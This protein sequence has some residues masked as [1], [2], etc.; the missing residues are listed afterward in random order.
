MSQWPLDPSPLSRPNPNRTPLEPT[1]PTGME[2]DEVL[3]PRTSR[4]HRA[5]QVGSVLAVLIVVVWAL[6][7]GVAPSLPGS[8]SRAP[9]VTSFSPTVAIT[10]NIS[11]WVATVTVNGRKLTGSLPLLTINVFHE[12]ANVVTLSA[13]PFHLH[14]CSVDLSS[15]GQTSG[16]SGCNVGSGSTTYHVNGVDVTP[17]FSVE[18]AFDSTDLPSDLAAS[19]YHT[20]AQAI[21]AAQLH[22]VVPSGQYYATGLDSKGHLITRQAATPLRA[23]VHFGAPDPQNPNCAGPCGAHMLGAFPLDPGI[24]LPDSQVGQ[25]LWSVYTFLTQSWRYTAA[26]GVVTVSP[27]LPFIASIQLILTYDHDPNTRGWSVL[28]LSSS[29]V[30][31]TGATGATGPS[32][33]T[34]T[35]QLSSSLCQIGTDLVTALAQNQNGIGTGTPQNLGVAGCEIQLLTADG[36]TQGTFLWRFGMLLVMDKGA[37][38]LAPWLPLAPYAEIVAVGG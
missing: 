34:F 5:V 37:H 36:S 18:F 28:S 15:S 33:P 25:R 3:R 30:S 16:S 38:T 29:P 27:Q 14:S 11:S 2:L 20:A 8:A 32:L 13:P 9:S 7:R 31:A 12:G 4:R 23:D 26:S 6:L 24:A 10:A 17:V 1:D 19:A 35:D 21:A 22:T